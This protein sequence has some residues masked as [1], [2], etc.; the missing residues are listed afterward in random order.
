MPRCRPRSTLTLVGLSPLGQPGF[1]ITVNAEGQIQLD[2][3][4]GRELSFES[5]Y[6]VADVQRTFFPWLG[7]PAVDQQGERSGQ[8]LGLTVSETFDQGVLKQR[9]FLRP[10][11]VERGQLVIDYQDWDKGADVPNRVI[12]H[13]RWFGYELVIETLSQS[14]L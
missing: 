4:S 1:V 12:V 13:N 10:D 8:V 5:N 6:I 9:R 7:Q 3:R 11:A 14:K 2:N